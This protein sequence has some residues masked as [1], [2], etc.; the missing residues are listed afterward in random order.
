MHHT[1]LAAVLL[2]TLVGSAAAQSSSGGSSEGAGGASGQPA[3]QPSG[4]RAPAN[5]VRAPANNV[6]SP[7][8]GVRAPGGGV[9]APGGGVRAPGG[10]VRAPG[11][12]VRAPGR[13]TYLIPPPNTNQTPPNNGGGGG[14][15]DPGDGYGGGHDGHHHD[16]NGHCR[17]VYTYPWN[18]WG[19]GW[20]SYGGWGWWVI[21][22][23]Y[24]GTVNG[25]AGVEMTDG[26]EAEP[27]EPPTPIEAARAWMAYGGFEEAV[28]WYRIYLNE[29]SGDTRVMRE[30]AAALLESGRPVDAV[31]M[32]GY[33][34]SI[35]PGLANEAMPEALWGDSPM[36]LRVSV[37]DA[38]NFGHRSPSGNAWL[39]VAVLMQAE[40]RDLVALKMVERAV[41]QGLSSE[42]ADRM[43]LRLSQR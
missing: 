13:P 6:R 29:N 38:V 35:E 21:P 32:M 15:W 39:L 19:W 22:D 30:Y 14:G 2:A 12:G 28:E 34:Y 40:G 25:P 8:G 23:A 24:T 10:G 26:R 18:W 31:A 27:A 5:T 16:D 42:V 4:V 36:R 41:D 3:R 17:I 33:A 9:R 43:R 1:R 11:G 7:G 20:G 37:V